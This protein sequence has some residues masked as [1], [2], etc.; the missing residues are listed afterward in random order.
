MPS[1]RWKQETGFISVQVIRECLEL[2]YLKVHFKKSIIQK[3]ERYFF[4]DHK[5]TA[6]T[7]IY[8]LGKRE[9]KLV[10]IKRVS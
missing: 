5:K 9:L 6:P 2:E 4:F 7:K 3:E 1:W 10:F 8:F